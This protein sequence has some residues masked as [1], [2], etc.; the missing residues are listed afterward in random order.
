[1]ATLPLGARLVAVD[2]APD[3]AAAAGGFVHRRHLLP[4]TAHLTDPVALAEQFVGTPYV[5]GGRTRVGI[6]CSGLTQA[7]LRA[8]GV[9]CPRDSDQQA[10]AFPAIDPD[11]RR[12]GDL[13]VFPGHVGLLSDR[14]TLLHATAHSMT[15]LAEP[16][17]AVA[18]RVAPSGFHR[19]PSI[20]ATPC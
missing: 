2:A 19:P 12:R 3:F 16:L 11:D 18:G 10:A 15:T 4:A 8:C 7:V 14:D 13:V 6:D 1:M 17:A 5:W 9:F 20:V